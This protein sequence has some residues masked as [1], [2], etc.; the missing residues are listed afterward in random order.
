[1]KL[2]NIFEQITFNTKKYKSFNNLS[3]E[4][5]YDISKWGLTDK[6]WC[7]QCIDKI[8]DEEAIICGINDFKVF[9]K[10]PYP[11][12]LGNF[13]TTP[14]IYRIVRLKNTSDLNKKDL[15]NSWFSNPTQYKEDGFFDALSHI[16]HNKNLEGETY[17]LKGKTSINNINIPSTLWERSTQFIENEIVVYNGGVVKL[18]SITKMSDL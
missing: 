13:P 16:E 9:L 17:L 12:G 7:S 5:L 11:F 2:L 15:G 4:D 8:V 18:L 10:E 1:M 14:I 3:D 6:Y